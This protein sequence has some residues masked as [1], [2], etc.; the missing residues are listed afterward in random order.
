MLAAVSALAIAGSGQGYAQ[1]QDEP[2]GVRKM[3]RVTVTAVKREQDLN[4]VPVS[5][6]A[7]TSDLREELGLANLS[8]FA[9]FTPSLAFSAGD[10]RVFIRGVRARRSAPRTTRHALRT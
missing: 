5:V 2:D 3:E 7:F 4:D 8:D 6:T 1:V 10:D 9:R